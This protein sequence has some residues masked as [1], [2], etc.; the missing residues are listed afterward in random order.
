MMAIFTRILAF[1]FSAA[2]LFSPVKTGIISYPLHNTS[3]EL[4]AD[5]IIVE[6]IDVSKGKNS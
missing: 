6:E 5:I 4:Q 2:V 1:I 3:D